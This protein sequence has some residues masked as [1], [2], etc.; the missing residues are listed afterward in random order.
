MLEDDARIVRREREIAYHRSWASAEIVSTLE[1]FG[2]SASD[3]MRSIARHPMWEAER[4]AMR[5]LHSV[6]FALPSDSEP[7]RMAM[8]QLAGWA[9]VCGEPANTYQREFFKEDC[10]MFAHTPGV[11]GVDVGTGAPGVVDHHCISKL[12][13]ITPIKIAVERPPLPCEK[14]YC[15]CYLRPVLPVENDVPTHASAPAI[16]SSLTFQRVPA[17]PARKITISLLAL[18]ILVAVASLLIQT[19]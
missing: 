8:L 17:Q 13:T 19:W 16:A 11:I 15:Y 3:V 1:Q 6:A 12:R 5:L 9:L 14:A 4:V 2:F 18:I 7:R 10:L